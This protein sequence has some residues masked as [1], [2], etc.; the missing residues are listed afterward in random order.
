MVKVV[1]KLID[2]KKDWK[3]YKKKP[4]CVKAV[5]LD[6]E[7]EVHTR[8]GVLKGFPGDFLIRGIKGEIYPCGREIFFKTYEGVERHGRE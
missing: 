7:I 3:W 5:E 8:E 2:V 1:K 4:I 6:E